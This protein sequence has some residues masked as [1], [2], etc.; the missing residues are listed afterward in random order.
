VLRSM[1]NIQGE[2][3]KGLISQRPVH[4]SNL[5]NFFPFPHRMPLR[6]IFINV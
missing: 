2:A 6:T 4:W 5:T 3:R 1:A